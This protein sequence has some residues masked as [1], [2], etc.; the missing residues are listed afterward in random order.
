MLHEWS[1]SRKGFAAKGSVEITADAVKILRLRHFQLYQRLVPRPDAPF[2]ILFAAA[3][4]SKMPATEHSHIFPGCAPS[5][6]IILPV[7]AVRDGQNHPGSCDV[8][9]RAHNRPSQRNAFLRLPG[10]LRTVRG[11]N[12]SRT[13][14]LNPLHPPGA[15][16]LLAPEPCPPAHRTTG[17]CFRTVGARIASMSRE[18]NLKSAGDFVGKSRIARNWRATR[19][20]N[21]AEWP[22][23][24]GSGRW[25][26]A[27]RLCRW[28]ACLFFG[29]RRPWILSRKRN[30]FEGQP[31]DP[32]IG[33]TRISHQ[34]S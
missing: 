13:S 31:H 33:L 22:N 7:R 24:A 11:A 1:I 30:K 25:H 12:E 28:A 21:G 14:R 15:M 27:G 5:H 8:S 26:G 6:G 34:V 23:R 19:T 4:D 3:L 20:G 9:S 32:P 18:S 29:R 2:G 17:I 16:I 10:Q